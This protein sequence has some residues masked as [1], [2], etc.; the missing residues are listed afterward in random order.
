MKAKIIKEEGSKGLKKIPNE[1]M[2]EEI[3]I[4]RQNFN[5]SKSKLTSFVII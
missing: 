4:A 1:K 5:N 2:T 3:E